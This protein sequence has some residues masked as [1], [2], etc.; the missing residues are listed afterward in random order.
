MLCMFQAVSPPI[1]RSS[2]CTHSIRYMSSLLAATAS[3]GEFA[4]P[5]HPLTPCI[6]LHFVGYYLKAYIN[7]ARYHERQT[8]FVVSYMSLLSPIGSVSICTNI[9]VR[10]ESDL[11]KSSPPSPSPH[12]VHPEKFQQE[13]LASFHAT[14][15][16]KCLSV[17]N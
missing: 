1:I 5:T 11:R 13:K 14:P 16:L 2:N 15:S 6:T 3:V 17:I 4:L 12:L 7:D 9:N 8:H 10:S